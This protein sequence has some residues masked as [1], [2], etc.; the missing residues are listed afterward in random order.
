MV[1]AHE[2]VAVQAGRLEKRGGTHRGWV[3]FM[4]R[5]RKHIMAH[6]M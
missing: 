3:Y 4:Y 1:D 5:C 2:A 6:P